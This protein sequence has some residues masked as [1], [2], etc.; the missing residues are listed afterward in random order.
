MVAL[1]LHFGS[2]SDPAGATAAARKFLAAMPKVDEV[3]S[4]PLLESDAEQIMKPRAGD[5][6]SGLRGITLTNRA[7]GDGH[8]DG[9]LRFLHRP[10]IGS[11][12]F[13]SSGFW[14]DAKTVWGY[15]RETAAGTVA[16]LRPLAATLGGLDPTGNPAASLRPIHLPRVFA[17][18][19]YVSLPGLPSELTQELRSL[20]DCTLRDLAD[21]IAIEAVNDIHSPPTRRFVQALN[22][23][24]VAPTVKYRHLTF[25]TPDDPA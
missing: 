13:F 8:W 24:P 23:L 16:S 4:E 25:P 2:S 1:L 5:F 21:G 18:W 22:A 15:M 11:S 20:P 9:T 14:P 3:R 7:V 6:E 10:G 19:T 17:P 12:L